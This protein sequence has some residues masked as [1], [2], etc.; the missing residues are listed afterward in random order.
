ML[1]FRRILFYSF[2]TSYLI[3]CPLTVLYAL[4]L[5]YKPGTE[6]GFVKTGLIYLSTA[7]PG[8]AIYLNQRHYAQA[9]P[10]M[11][12]NLIPNNYRVRIEMPG[13]QA[14]EQT[15][16]VKAEKASAL[17][18]VLLLPKEW[19][20]A[21][22]TEGPFVDLRGII[23]SKNILLMSGKHLKE[24]FVYSL[25]KKKIFEV[26][27]TSLAD[28]EVDDLYSV[29]GSSVVIFKLVLNEKVSYAKLDLSNDHFLLTDISSV[30]ANGFTHLKWSSQN[31]DILYCWHDGILDKLDVS[32][33]TVQSAFV[34]DVQGYGANNHHLY[35]LKK[36]GSLIK[37]DDKGNDPK[38]LSRDH[39]TSAEIFQPGKFYDIYAYPP[40]VLVLV[41]ESGD[42]VTNRL[43]YR[44]VDSHVRTFEF[45]KKSK[46]LLIL[47]DSLLGVLDFSVP[48]TLSDEAFQVGSK[49]SWVLKERQNMAQAFW[50]YEGSHILF[51]E[52]NKIFILDF[53]T[54]EAP[55]ENFVVEV[56]NGSSVYFSED[57][58]LLYYLDASSGNLL[59]L[60][61]FPK[62]QIL[63]IPFPER[64]EPILREDK[65][66]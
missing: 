17:D 65:N 8:A 20:S 6:Y 52:G 38:L 63:N 16:P 44:V 54:Y 53:E 59:S 60:E 22:L 36:N 47:R 56:K 66:E 50:V 25:E 40:D 55:K 46:R 12:R 41:G 28:Y 45:S 35:V 18:F 62:K 5:I 33:G 39:A 64:T 23:G 30:L 24:Y 61:V 57:S 4:G 19:K 43:P 10:A 14:W 7:P 15:I 1:I 31:A 34:K 9:A 48:E 21:T 3:T 58:G 2:L 32:S 49:L 13:Y 11:I 42:L 37:T 29:P 26:S 51:R 27:Q